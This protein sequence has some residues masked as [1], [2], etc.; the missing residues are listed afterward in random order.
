MESV[1]VTAHHVLP[2]LSSGETA[3]QVAITSLSSGHRFEARVAML[4]SRT[5][6]AILT[7]NA[8]LG[9]TIDAISASD[10]VRP[11]A[12][13]AITG[14]GH[15][16]DPE[17]EYHFLDAIGTWVG[18][19]ERDQVPLARMHC[20]DL[21]LGLSGS[22]VRL[23]DSSKRETVVGVVSERYNS[24]DGW[25]RDSVWLAR[26][27][28]LQHLVDAFKSRRAA[29]RD[30]LSATNRER[31][32]QQRAK[33]VLAKADAEIE[34]IRTARERAQTAK[35]EQEAKPLATPAE[36]ERTRDVIHRADREIERMRMERER[37]IDQGIEQILDTT[38]YQA[39]PPPKASGGRL[40]RF[41]SSL[42]RR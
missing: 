32:R 5:D 2:G 1:F 41:L 36:R 38:T 15:I 24:S 39:P 9:A 35:R 21:L 28:D 19:A 29:E 26:S 30:A 8:T 34:A 3:K 10:D 7:S 6:L 4:D 13:V 18:G 42:W 33:Q 40:R 14:Y 17:H 11:G 23:V 27:E 20:Q 31:A 37:R 22:P 25:L 12:L 16:D